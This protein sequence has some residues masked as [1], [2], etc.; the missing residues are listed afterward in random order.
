MFVG[1]GDTARFLLLSTAGHRRSSL[2]LRDRLAITG[3]YR[4]CLVSREN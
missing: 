2:F 3:V 1:S 4:K